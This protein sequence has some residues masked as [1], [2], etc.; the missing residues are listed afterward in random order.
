M[1][2]LNKLYFSSSMFSRMVFK[3]NKEERWGCSPQTPTR[4]LRTL[5]PQLANSLSWDKQTSSACRVP[6][7]FC[8]KQVQ[9]F[10]Q[11]K[12]ATE[13][14]EMKSPGAG[15][16]GLHKPSPRSVLKCPSAHPASETRKRR[17]FTATYFRICTRAFFSRRE[18]WAWEMPISPAT[19]IW[20]RPS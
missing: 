9:L 5:D 18:T 11:V 17:Q 19:S 10:T 3:F 20:V 6:S 4:V 8:G 1:I 14:Q 13:V 16:R 7:C 12:S 15:A 2:R